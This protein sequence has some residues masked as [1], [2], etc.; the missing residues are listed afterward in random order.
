MN[1][2][3]FFC[4]LAALTI[5]SANAIAQEEHFDVFVGISGSDTAYGGI[6]VDEG[7]ITPDE[8]IFEAELEELDLGPGLGM[9][10]TGDEP[11]F[12]HPGPADAGFG[13]LPPG[14]TALAEFDEVFV[15]KLPLTIDGT[16]ADLFFWDGTGTPSF[17]EATG[18]LFDIVAGT[19]GSI[20]DAGLGGDFDDHPEF[21][22]S[23]PSGSLPTPGIYIG[24][25]DVR[26]NS[27]S[28]SDQL[29][30]VM[31]TDGLAPTDEELEELIEMGVDFVA[32]NVIPEPSAIVLLAI[33]GVGLL[34]G[35]GTR[36]S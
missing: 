29:F 28:A 14:V 34:N 36:R 12:N 20:G 4:T 8:R 24:S 10:F 31:G 25:F 3:L 33:A 9:I 7:D 23:T 30:L 18:T 15:N 27:L 21:E 13:M 26:V 16:T 2:S 1:R 32:T 19:G 5:T 35:R 6:D 11:G 22:L 17:S